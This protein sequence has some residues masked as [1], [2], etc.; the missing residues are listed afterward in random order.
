MNTCFV[1]NL[2]SFQY[3]FKL[4]KSVAY[5]QSYAYWKSQYHFFLL[6]VVIDEANYI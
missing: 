6:S 1:A 4:L 5:Y 2:L 3:N